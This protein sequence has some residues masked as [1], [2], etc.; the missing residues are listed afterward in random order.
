MI[1]RDPD[2][3]HPGPTED[4]PPAPGPR[5]RRRSVVRRGTGEPLLPDTTR[6]ERDV[7]W[8]DAPERDDDERLLREVPP[9]HGS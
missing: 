4:P 2:P 9:H 8:G 3:D 7:G 5:V 6:D 1:G